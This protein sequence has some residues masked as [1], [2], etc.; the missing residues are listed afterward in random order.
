MLVGYN[1]FS[2]SK[3]EKN[4]SFSTKL[5]NG[6]VTFAVVDLA[7]FFFRMTSLQEAF[8]ILN[9]MTKEL[10]DFSD[11]LSVLGDGDRNILIVGMLILFVVDFVHEKGIRIRDWVKG[12]EVWF[13]Y[14]LYI[15][16]ISACIYLG[17][18][19]EVDGVR[20]FIYFQF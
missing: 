20:Q 9:Q 16:V 14:I 2:S 12:Q 18:H 11:I 10:G 5:R 15:G 6:I 17:V 19:S 8:A 7:W 4:V 1:L 13:R 3:K